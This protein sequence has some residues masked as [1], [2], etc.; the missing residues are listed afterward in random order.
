MSFGIDEY[1]RWFQVPV[2]HSALMGILNGLADLLKEPKSLRPRNIVFLHI[3]R[4]GRAGH[5]FHGE[6]VFAIRGAT[7]LVHRRN[8]RMLKPPERLGF[9][10]KKAEAIIVCAG[11]AAH[12]FDGDWPLSRWLLGFVD[13]SHPS[14]TQPA[15][16]DIRADGCWE[17]VHQGN[18]NGGYRIDSCA[19]FIRPGFTGLA[20][21]NMLCDFDGLPIQPTPKLGIAKMTGHGSIFGSKLGTKK[22][23]KPNLP[24]VACP[25]IINLIVEIAPSCR[26]PNIF[27]NFSRR[28]G[29]TG[30]V[31]GRLGL[32][33]IFGELSFLALICR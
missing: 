10:L 21:F 25:G 18:G 17:T 29:L 6:K 14:F 3:L 16:Y 1:V 15:L 4:Q 19:E 22:G 7:G 12:H 33:K 27:E 11:S 13:N 20:F 8:G 30:I 2:Y 26:K 5:Q 31:K 24:L 28:F 9:S 32:A 23:L